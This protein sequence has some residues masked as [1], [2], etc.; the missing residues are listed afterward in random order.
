MNELLQIV[1]S[2]R[3]RGYSDLAVNPFA[4]SE[5]WII[6][7]RKSPNRRNTKRKKGA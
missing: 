6:E 4:I 5:R 1:F 3:N 7:L 2:A